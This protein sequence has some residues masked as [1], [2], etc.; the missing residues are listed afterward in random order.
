MAHTGRVPTLQRPPGR[1]LPTSPFTREEYVPP[2][3]EGFAVGDRVT[4]DSW[5]MGRVREVTEHYLV[6]DFGS[7]GL[8]RIPAGTKG[9]SLL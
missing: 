3:T 7:A 8:R 9:F 5:G 6:V 4:L 1:S 2:S